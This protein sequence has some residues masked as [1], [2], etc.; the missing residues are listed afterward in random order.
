ML[1]TKGGRSL[2][3]RLAC[4]SGDVVK[5]D[6]CTPYLCEAQGGR[7]SRNTLK[8]VRLIGRRLN[9][10]ANAFQRRR[11]FENAVG[12]ESSPHC[13]F[14]QHLGFQPGYAIAGHQRRRKADILGLNDGIRLDLS[15]STVGR[16]EFLGQILS[17]TTRTMTRMI[18]A[19]YSVEDEVGSNPVVLLR[20][21]MTCQA[22]GPHLSL[23]VA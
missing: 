6:D 14:E 12:K 16:A 23:S 7:R 5:D 18:T 10:R 2:C 17:T 13:P 1:S 4:G 20:Q 15:S 8:R 22:R 11:T 9:L 21:P 19:I 3:L